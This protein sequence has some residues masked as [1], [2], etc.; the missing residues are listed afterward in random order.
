MKEVVP[1]YFTKYIPNDTISVRS[2][3][4]S[5]FKKKLAKAFKDIAKS[6]KGK[7]IL[8]N[9]YSHYGYTDS[10]DSNFDVVREY[11]KVAKKATDSK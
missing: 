1:I 2:D 4:S 7:K 10:K 6:P 11:E 5:A 8:E 3:L 9:I